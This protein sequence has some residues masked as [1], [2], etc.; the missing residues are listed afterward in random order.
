MSYRL[1]ELITRAMNTP[2]GGSLYSNSSHLREQNPGMAVLETRDWDFDLKR[3]TNHGGCA[4]VMVDSPLAW[5]RFTWDT[6]K[7]AIEEDVKMGHVEVIWMSHRLKVLW[8]PLD[9]GKKH[10][11]IIAET[12]AVAEAFFAAVCR[13]ST[14]KPDRIQVYSSGYFS[15]DQS[16]VAS[17]EE[18]ELDQITLQAELKQEILRATQGFFESEERYSQAGVAWKRG[19][20]FHGPPGNGKTH[21]VKALV[22]HLDKPCLYVRTLESGDSSI[23][24]SIGNVFS[25]AREQAP[26]ILVL[27]D[28]D[29]LLATKRIS[30][31]LNEID[32]FAKNHGI[33]ILATTNYLDRLDPA[34]SNRPSR[35][36]RKFELPLPSEALRKAFI[37]KFVA[38]W[39]VERHP[40]PATLEKLARKSEGFSFVHLK[41]ICVDALAIQ[42]EEPSS[43]PYLS[44]LK[45]VRKETGR[46]SRRVT[47]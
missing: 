43:D 9:H 13:F 30:V 24:E 37:E 46:E 41:E 8:I 7:K 12:Y 25:R 19:V 18:A 5:S 26:C 35:F 36:D 10:H 11:F 1:T 47:P 22:K 45:S 42:L 23:E 39:P 21:L 40:A 44:A 17:I 29:S 4:C 20:I 15:T 34:L 32:G 3:F 28:V 33:L 27:E 6:Y 2:T 31:L 14:E 16:L 38:K